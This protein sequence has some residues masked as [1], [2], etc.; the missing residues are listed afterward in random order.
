MRFGTTSRRRVELFSRLF[1]NVHLKA[2]LVP[3]IVEQLADD[4]APAAIL[5]NDE[6]DAILAEAKKADVHRTQ[7]LDVLSYRESLQPLAA[8]TPE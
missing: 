6:F 5:S 8:R 3:N 4:H 7:S 1:R 2:C